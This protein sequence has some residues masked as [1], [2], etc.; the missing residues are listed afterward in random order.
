MKEKKFEH[1][2]G[3][4]M[5]AAQQEVYKQKGIKTWTI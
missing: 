1:V 3:V 4:Q 2:L 5:E